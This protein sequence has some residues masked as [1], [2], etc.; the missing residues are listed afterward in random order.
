VLK[1]W[2]S[3]SSRSSGFG[4]GGVF[5]DCSLLHLLPRLFFTC[6]GCIKWAPPQ[7]PQQTTP[8]PTPQP[9]PTNKTTPQK[10]PP[11][12]PA[13]WHS[14]SPPPPQ[15]LPCIVLLIWFLFGRSF[16]NR[17]VCCHFFGK[18]S[19]EIHRIFFPPFRGFAP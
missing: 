7:Q 1:P 9:K 5:E 12:R 4:R 6:G 11:T 15:S 16:P 19:L 3:F 14:L 13:F 8:T 2:R 17:L 10:N 18:L